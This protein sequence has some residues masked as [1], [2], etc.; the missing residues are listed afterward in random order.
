MIG[1][2]SFDPFHIETK[3]FKRRAHVVGLDKMRVDLVA[4]FHKHLILSIK[5][6]IKVVDDFVVGH[7]LFPSRLYGRDQFKT[8]K[9]ASSQLL[10]R[11]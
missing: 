2:I 4:D 10:T 1:M 11:R 3:L 6:V 5:P 8:S 7:Y 9:P